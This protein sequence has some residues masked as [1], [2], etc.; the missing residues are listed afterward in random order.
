MKVN[1]KVGGNSYTKSFLFGVGTILIAPFVAIGCLFLAVTLFIL[2][3]LGFLNF[4]EPLD[5]PTMEK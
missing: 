1:F 2:G 5:K 4:D 3:L